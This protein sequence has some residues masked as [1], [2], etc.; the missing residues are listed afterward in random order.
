M[1]LS[2]FQ[3]VGLLVALAAGSVHSQQQ[4]LRIPPP[5]PQAVSPT[6]ALDTRDA[7]PAPLSVALAFSRPATVFLVS[8]EEPKIEAVK[9]AGAKELQPIA[10]AL[11][12]AYP[13]GSQVAI[14]W[15]GPPGPFSVSLMQSESAVCG[16]WSFGEAGRATGAATVPLNRIQSAWVGPYYLHARC[17]GAEWKS[18][19]FLILRDDDDRGGDWFR[20]AALEMARREWGRTVKPDAR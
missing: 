20:R 1:S 12:K 15:A 14:A 11:V 6:F 13:S 2:T 18:E 16:S 4:P 3:T 5:S 9:E 10:A 7:Q 8:G 19:P 17:G